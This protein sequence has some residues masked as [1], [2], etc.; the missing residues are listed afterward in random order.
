MSWPPSSLLSCPPASAAA[1]ASSAAVASFASVILFCSARVLLC[2]P[3][4]SAFWSSIFRF[5]FASSPEPPPL[6]RRFLVV[7]LRFTQRL[8]ACCSRAL[9]LPQPLVHVPKLALALCLERFPPSLRPV[10]PQP[11]D[12]AATL[13]CSDL[14]L[15]LAPS[16]HALASLVLA[17]VVLPLR[18]FSATPRLHV[19][20]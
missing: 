7:C 4:I 13:I 16:L 1:F 5:H 15:L 20:R 6:P 10:H 19:L 14:L 3:A 18:L 12:L 9:Q 8:F 17:F 11:F 2:T